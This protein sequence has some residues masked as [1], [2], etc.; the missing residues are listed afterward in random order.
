MKKREQMLNLLKPILLKA[1]DKE[2]NHLLYDFLVKNS[3]LPGRRANLELAKAFGDF[4]LL[5]ENADLIPKIRYIVDQMIS[6]TSFQA[7]TN[8]PKEFIPFCGYFALG[9]LVNVENELFENEL[10]ENAI[11]KFK[12]AA[13]DSRWRIREAVA[14]GIEF[15]ILK[16]PQRTL[17]ELSHWIETENFLLIRG[18]LAGLTIIKYLEIGKYATQFLQLCDKVMLWLNSKKDLD[19]K[20]EDFKVLQKGLNYVISVGVASLPELGFSLMEKWKQLKNPIITKIIMQNCSKARLVKN[21]P[22]QVK[23]IMQ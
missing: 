23:K 15:F 12:E 5:N 18:A 10:F 3:N 9:A 20:D 22:N 1:I 19:I 8:N 21:Y 6:V 11:E 7:P 13:I 4:I 14:H 2:D 16:F 17:N